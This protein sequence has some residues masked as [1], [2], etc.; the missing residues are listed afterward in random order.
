MV[1]LELRFKEFALLIRCFKLVVF[2]LLSIQLG[3]CEQPPEPSQTVVDWQIKLEDI[4]LQI[5]PGNIPVE[6]L[7]TMQLKSDA[8]LQQVSAELTGVNMYM[9]RIP[10]QFRYNAADDR[11]EADFMLGSCAE[12]KMIWKL[13]I[14]L[15]DMQGK[16]RQLVTELQSSWG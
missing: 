13:T 11:W 5:S 6:T 1:S 16:S 8:K 15:I 10:L 14:T 9:G 3:G 7:L 12:P 2:L 4:K